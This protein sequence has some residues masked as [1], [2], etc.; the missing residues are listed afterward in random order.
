MEFIDSCK[1]GLN[2]AKCLK[3]NFY[4]DVYYS[5]ECIQL[6]PN[7]ILG[8]ESFEELLIIPY[9]FN[10]NEIFELYEYKLSIKV[11]R[12]RKSKEHFFL[13]ETGKSSL[14]DIPLEILEVLD[15]TYYEVLEN[16]R[17]TF[18]KCLKKYINYM[19]EKESNMDLSQ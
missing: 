13:E 10:G 15:N 19:L 7:I 12:E 16:D 18:V 6:L 1:S 17:T 5:L 3:I 4:E 9:C 11:V 2:K 14:S 8:K